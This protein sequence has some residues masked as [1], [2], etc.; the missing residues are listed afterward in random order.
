MRRHPTNT[1]KA[2]KKNVKFDLIYLDGLHTFEQTL[3]DLLNS[4]QFL[5]P[6]GLIIVDDVYPSDYLASLP[7]HQLMLE[8]KAQIGDADRNWMGDVYKTIAFARKF[9]TNF[10]FATTEGPLKQTIF[11]RNNRTRNEVVDPGVI[12]EIAALQFADIRN[13][14]SFYNFENFKTIEIQI[15]KELHLDD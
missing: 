9:L 12:Q 2:W 15:R 7:N 8:L 5:S 4:M 10:N 3:L 14:P 11:W 1:L 6:K 13:D